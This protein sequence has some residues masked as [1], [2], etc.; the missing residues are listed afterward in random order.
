[1]A[2]SPYMHVFGE[3]RIKRLL[4]ATRQPTWNNRVRFAD[5]VT[6]G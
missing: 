1:M 3:G 5:K 4:V 2:C 6:L